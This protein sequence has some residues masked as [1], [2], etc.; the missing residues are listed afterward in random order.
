MRGIRPS[1]SVSFASW[2]TPMIVPIA[3]KKPDSSTVKTNRQPVSRPT[4]S[5]PPKRLTCPSRE[6]S[7]VLTIFSG[8]LGTARPHAASG[9]SAMTLITTATTVIAT[10]LIRIAPLTPRVTRTNVNARPSTKT[11]TGQPVN[12]PP[13]PRPSGTVVCAASG[14]RVTNPESTRPMKVMNRPMPIAMACRSP[15]GMAS[16]TR[17]RSPEATRSIST[18]PAR[19]TMPM[20]SGQLIWGASWRETTALMPRPA[21]RAMGTLPT[22]PIRRVVRPA[23]SAVAVTSWALSSWLPN[24]SWPAPRMIGFSTMM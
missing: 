4:S 23:I 12:W 24:L 11:S 8:M 21:A 14:L 20:A 9:I 5:K 13:C 2:P 10:M 22:T 3:S 6:K 19:T 16:M 1:S 18:K 7:G 15:L 17:S